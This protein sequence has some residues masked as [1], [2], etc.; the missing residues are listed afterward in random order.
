MPFCLSVSPS[1]RPLPLSLHLPLFC[2]L[3]LFLL[4]LFS[5]NVCLFLNTSLTLNLPNSLFFTT[6]LSI[7]LSVTLSLCHSVSLFLCFFVSLHLP[8]FQSL[9]GTLS[10]YTSLYFA[11][12]LLLSLFSANVCFFF[13]FSLSLSYPLFLSL[14]LSPYISLHH[15]LFCSITSLLSLFFALFLFYQCLSLFTG[16]TVATNN[17]FNGKLKDIEV[18][19]FKDCL[20]DFVPLILS[21]SNLLVKK[22]SGKEITCGELSNYI[23]AFVKIFGVIYYKPE[24]FGIQKLQRYPIPD[25]IL[26]DGKVGIISSRCQSYH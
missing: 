22:I 9:S 18:Q 23:P 2:L 21:P 14:P 1:L 25:A 6:A 24:T 11:P 17:N 26:A 7:Y 4:S 5:T 13:F 20:K 12:S 8:L 19:E 16:T 10:L 3:Y 15:P